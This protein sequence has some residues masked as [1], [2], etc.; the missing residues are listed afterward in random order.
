MALTFMVQQKKTIN[1]KRSRS[2]QQKNHKGTKEMDVIQ[3]VKF[4]GIE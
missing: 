2:I 3:Y 4:E 1:P